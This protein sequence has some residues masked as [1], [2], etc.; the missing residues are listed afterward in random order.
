MRFKIAFRNLQ[1]MKKE[2]KIAKV[3]NWYQYNNF[4]EVVSAAFGHK[5][6]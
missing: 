6:I 1:K 3:N 4:N 2:L 5:L